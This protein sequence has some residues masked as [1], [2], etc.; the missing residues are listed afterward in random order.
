MNF[1]GFACQ[2]AYELFLGGLD[3]EQAHAAA[4]ALE[5]GLPSTVKC[6]F[7]DRATQPGHCLDGHTHKLKL[8]VDIQDGATITRENGAPLTL[9]L[10]TEGADLTIIVGLQAVRQLRQ[11]LSW[12]DG[13]TVGLPGR[14]PDGRPVLLPD[15]YRG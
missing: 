11:M 15:V 9:H 4:A 7:D 10:C 1:N 5:E 13:H 6:E 8:T 3:P 14:M 12:A 2:R